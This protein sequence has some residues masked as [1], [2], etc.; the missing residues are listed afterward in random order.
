METGPDAA[1]D[2]SGP[3]SAVDLDKTAINES[4]LGNDPARQNID[5]DSVD[6][7]IAEAYARDVGV[8]TDTST[9][10]LPTDAEKREE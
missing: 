8:P 10:F 4:S 2:S 6:A 3:I 5:V 7:D 9:A 1:P